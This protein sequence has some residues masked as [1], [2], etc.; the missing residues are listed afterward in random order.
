[1]MNHLPMR[2]KVRSTWVS[3]W[4]FDVLVNKGPQRATANFMALR[5]LSEKTTSRPNSITTRIETGCVDYLVTCPPSSS[6]P[7]SIT[8]RIETSN[9]CRVGLSPG[10]SRPNSITTRIETRRDPGLHGARR[11]SRPNSITTRI[12]TRHIHG[13][14]GGLLEPSR[15]NSITTRI[16]T[17]ISAGL[18]GCC[19]PPQGQIPSQQGLKQDEDTTRLAGEDPQGQIPSQQGL[20]PQDLTLPFE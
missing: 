11:T 8:T 2:T 18:P 6:R 17:C 19:F 3:G 12:E 9:G 14:P 20:K 13:E 10:T 4:I 1:M 15:P 7:N 5:L 16:E